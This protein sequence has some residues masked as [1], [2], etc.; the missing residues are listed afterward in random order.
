M[1]EFNILEAAGLPQKKKRERG[2]TITKS[3]KKSSEELGFDFY[4]GERKYGYGGYLYDGRWQAVAKVAQERYKLNQKSRVLIDRCHK[5][6]LVYDLKNLIPGITV[7][8]IH[9]KEYAINH[10]M[11]GFGRWALING[12]EKNSDHKMIEE[13]AKQKILPFLIA[14]NSKDLPFKDKFFDSVISIE[15][16]CSYFEND[17]R[18]VVKEIVRI[19]KDRGEKSYIQNDSWTNENEKNKLRKW[20]FLCKTFLSTKEWEKLYLEEGYNG[21]WGYTI[22]E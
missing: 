1:A 18:N 21:D 7:Y 9:P 5:G 10:C 2:I 17:C 13:R 15:N 3:L 22:I 19:T 14:G 4:D 12:V 20:S 8:G 16:A 6:F 11:E